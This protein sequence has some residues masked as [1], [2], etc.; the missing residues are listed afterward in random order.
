MVSADALPGADLLDPSVWQATPRLV[1]DKAWIPPSWGPVLQP[2]QPWVEGNAV[3]GPDGSIYNLLR[4]ENGWSKSRP[5]A[6]KAIL[7]RA[8]HPTKRQEFV[9]IYDMP[10]GS[11]KFTVRRD[12]A[13]RRYIALTNNVTNVTACP[14]ARNVLVLVSSAD[15]RD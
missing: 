3:Q 14:S 13:S 8:P 15:L 12:P 4:L 10:G 2:I 1:F 11:S 7:L 9:G 5:V 6:N